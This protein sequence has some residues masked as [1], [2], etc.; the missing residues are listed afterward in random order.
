MLIENNIGIIIGIVVHARKRKKTNNIIQCFVS[1][2]TL[3]SPRS[4]FRGVLEWNK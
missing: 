4:L 2:F 3:I 1:I